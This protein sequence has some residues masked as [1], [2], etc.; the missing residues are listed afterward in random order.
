MS[1]SSSSYDIGK[2]YQLSKI[3][4][5]YR[6][7]IRELFDQYISDTLS[8]IHTVEGFCERHPRWIL[9]RKEEQSQMKNIKDMAEGIDPNFDK[10]IKSEDKAKAFQEFTK[11]YL[12]QVTADNRHK[13]LEKELEDV[14]KDTLKGLEELEYF[15]DAMERLVVTSVFVFADENRLC[16]LPQGREPS[17]VRAV[18]TSARMACPLLIHFKRDASA[19]FSPCL[20]NVEVLY[21]YLENY[22]HISEQLCERMRLGNVMNQHLRLTFLFQESALHFIDLF[23]QRHSRMLDFL[24]ELERRAVKLEEMKFGSDISSVAGSAVGA[25]GGALTIAG[26]CLAP[27]TVGLS[28][29]LTIA[30]LGLGVTSGVNGV[31]T[32]V[33]EIIVNRYHSKEVNTVFQHFIEDMQILRGSLEK[34]ASRILPVVG[35]NMVALGVG[36]IMGKGAVSLGMKINGIVKNNSAIEALKGNGMVMGAGKVGLGGGNKLAADLP[37]IGMLAQGTPLALSK[38]LRRCNVAL[39]ALFIGLDIITIYKDS[40]SLAKGSKSED[41]QLIRARVALWRTE[42]NSCQ[43]IHDSLCQGIRRFRQSQRILEKPFYLVKELESLE[44]LVEMGLMDSLRMI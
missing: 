31:T 24:K 1:S 34:V 25:T 2:Y 8:Y 42:I 35:F 17:S 7:K 11:K 41:S 43:R 4:C 30:G 12:T 10:V 5:S 3:L 9:Q 19:F 39:N 37:D 16:P 40:V 27:V 14:L 18:I 20:L 44:P 22:I 15:M 28:L 6:E 26:L 23:S 36:V 32:G 21:V 29:W 38:T 13:E 33:T